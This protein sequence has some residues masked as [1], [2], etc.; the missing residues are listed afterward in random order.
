MLKKNLFT[1][2]SV[3]VLNTFFMNIHGYIWKYTNENPVFVYSNSEQSHSARIKQIFQDYQ[4]SFQD[5]DHIDKTS[6]ALYVLFNAANIPA[7]NLPKYYI[8]FQN[9]DLNNTAFT[10]EY[11]AKLGNAIAVWDYNWDNINKYRTLNNYYYFPENYEYSDPVVLSCFLPVKTLHDY[12]ALLMYSNRLNSDISSHLPVIFAHTVLQNPDGIIEA[13]VRG[14]ESTLAFSKAMRFCSSFLI[15]IDIDQYP[16][17]LYSTLSN[18]K[19]L[20]MDDTKFPHTYAHDAELNKHALDI[21]FIDTS[22]LYQHTLQEIQGFTSTLSPR[23]YL[24]F[25]DSNMSTGPG[26]TW[27]TLN[28]ATVGQGWDNQRGVIRA[29]KDFFGLT[30]DESRYNSFTFNKNGFVWHILHYP[31]CNGFTIIKKV[32]AA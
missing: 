32:S 7:E 26:H 5:V 15:G 22:H 25:H 31:Y 21:I 9:L 27:Y 16:N 4:I 3:I 17:K 29:I 1:L 18:A 12:K 11:A 30:F 2:L 10:E 19:F 13:G 24:S 20:W 23:G 8:I 6:D 28:G 14:G